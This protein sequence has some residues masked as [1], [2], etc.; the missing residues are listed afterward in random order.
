MLFDKDELT[1]IEFSGKSLA[2]EFTDN[3]GSLSPSA[4]PLGNY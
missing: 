2:I 3:S 1:E 4:S